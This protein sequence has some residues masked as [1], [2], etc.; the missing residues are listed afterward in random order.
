[1]ELGR[2]GILL[3]VVGP[4]GCGKTSLCRRLLQDLGGSLSFSVSLTSRPK[5][6]QEKEGESY[7]FVAREEFEQRIKQ[8]DLL[9]WEEV[10]GN[11]Y[12][13]L[14]C[15]LLDAVDSGRDLLLDIDVKGALNIRQQFSGQA[16]SV[17]VTPPS[18]ALL[19]ERLLGRGPMAPEEF[20]RRMQTARQEYRML[21][22]QLEQTARFDYLVINAD[23]DQ[24]LSELKAIV[25]AERRRI[26]RL[27]AEAVRMIGRM[28]EG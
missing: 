15:V 21:T 24:A 2:R 12:G 8:G 18:Y 28:D 20:K 17:F 27:D 6:P 19:K 1:M 22:D 16:V 10:H 9:E 26:S 25:L 5:R 3:S 11:L 4:A 7:F 13:T 14:R 23:F